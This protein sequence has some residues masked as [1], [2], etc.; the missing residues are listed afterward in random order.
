ML[1]IKK[2]ESLKVKTYFKNKFNLVKNNWISILYK[3]ELCIFTIWIEQESYANVINKTL[4]LI[5][6]FDSQNQSE[7]YLILLF[8]LNFNTYLNLEMIQMNL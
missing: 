3:I 2:L 8:V 6:Y 4:H 7:H 1:I 5:I